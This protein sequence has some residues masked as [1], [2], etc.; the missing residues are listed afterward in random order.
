MMRELM[1]LKVKKHQENICMQILKSYL[2]IN[3]F[4]FELNMLFSFENCQPYEVNQAKIEV[5][6][7]E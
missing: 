6:I 2:G 7:Q 5:K 1:A 4:W 3:F